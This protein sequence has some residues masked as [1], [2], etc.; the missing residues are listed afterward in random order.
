GPPEVL[1]VGAGFIGFIVLNAMYK[2]GWKLHVVEMA[3]HVLPRMLDADAARVVE[4]WLR[5]KGV[6]LHLGTTVSGGITMRMLD[7]VKE[8]PLGDGNVIQANAVVVATG[9]RPN[10]DLVQGSGIAVD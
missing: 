4:A 1:F 7:S 2:R 9:I 5:Q 3:D 8:V 10:T 6:S